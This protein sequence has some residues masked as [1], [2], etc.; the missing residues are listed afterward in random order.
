MRKMR[1][2]SACDTRDV[3]SDDLKSNKGRNCGEVIRKEAKCA[4]KPPVMAKDFT[5]N[6]HKSF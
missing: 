6:D 3:A 2:K 4:G 1:Q 5:V